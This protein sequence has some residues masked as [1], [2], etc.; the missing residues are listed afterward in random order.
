MLYIDL[1]FYLASEGV[2]GCVLEL[3]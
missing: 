2:R 3:L 1:F